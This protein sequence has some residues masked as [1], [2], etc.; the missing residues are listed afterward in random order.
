MIQ[1]GGPPELNWCLTE[2]HCQLFGTPSQPGTTCSTNASLC[3]ANMTFLGIGGPMSTNCTDNP[4]FCKFNM[5]RLEPSCT[6]DLFMGNASYTNASAFNYT[7]HFDGLNVLAQSIK[8]LG[9]LGLSKAKQILFTGVAWGGTAVFLHADRVHAMIKSLSPGLEKF[10]ALP[11]DGLHP[12]QGSVIYAGN[13]MTGPQPDSWLTGA[14]QTMGTLA[15]VD[16]AVNDGCRAANPGNNSWNCLYVNESLPYIK[17]SLFAVNQMLSVWDSQVRPYL[18][19]FSCSCSSLFSSSSSPFS[20]R[21]C[22][23]AAVPDRRDTRA[24]HPASFLLAEGAWM[25][26]GTAVQPVPGVLH[27]KLHRQCYRAQAA[28]V[29]RR[30]R[31]VRSAQTKGQRWVLPFVLPWLVFSE[32]LGRDR[33]LEHHR[34]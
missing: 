18:R 7:L 24:R 28:T 29:H 6:F 21:M 32:R 3:P 14:L 25:G 12:R 8:K 26:Y 17:T 23:C 27:F 19:S 10:K 31:A 33:D 5:A 22:A 4:D 2:A 20:V 15:N 30:L 1:L 11:V 16:G 9:Q 34:D 13:A